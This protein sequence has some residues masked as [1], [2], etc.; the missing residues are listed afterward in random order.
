MAHYS[1]GAMPPYLVNQSRSFSGT[2]KL[3]ATKGINC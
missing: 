2:I 3:I 1:K